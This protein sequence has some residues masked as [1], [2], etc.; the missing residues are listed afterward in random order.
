MGV[1]N[2]KDNPYTRSP[3]NVFVSFLSTGSTN[4]TYFP[5]TLR[6][7]CVLYSFRPETSVP[8]FY[9]RINYKYEFG[10]VR[11]KSRGR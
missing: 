9:R 3:V 11:N 2:S 4:T 1:T 7:K 10:C 8:V 5:V 6:T